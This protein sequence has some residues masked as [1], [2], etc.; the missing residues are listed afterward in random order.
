[1]KD[2]FQFCG[3]PRGK[4]RLCTKVRNNICVQYNKQKGVYSTTV[5]IQKRYKDK[6]AIINYMHSDDNLKN[7][8]TYTHEWFFP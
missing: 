8:L 7:G 2:Q 5:I 6:Y 3:P 4:Q 1:M